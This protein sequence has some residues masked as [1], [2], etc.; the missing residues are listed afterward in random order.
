MIQVA[1]PPSGA[2]L[3]TLRTRVK[4]SILDVTQHAKRIARLPSDEFSDWQGAHF[5]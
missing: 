3:R 1:L 4:T 2:Q 5:P